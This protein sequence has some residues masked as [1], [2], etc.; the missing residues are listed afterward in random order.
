MPDV[1]GADGWVTAVIPIGSVEHALHD[2]LRFGPDAEVLEP[3]Q[4]RARMADAAGG[5]AARYGVL[6]PGR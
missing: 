1:F 4:L 6:S 3:A 2:L 5:L